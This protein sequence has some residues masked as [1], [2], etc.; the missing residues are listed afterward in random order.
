ML[1]GLAAA[2]TTTAAFGGSCS[3]GTGGGAPDKNRA[4]RRTGIEG[5]YVMTATRS[6]IDATPEHPEGANDNWGSFRL[7]LGK[8][9]FRM[10]DQRPAGAALVQQSSS[11]FSA[12]TYAVHGD[13]ITFSTRRASGDTPLGAAGDAPIVCRWSIYRSVLT[14]RELPANAK[15]SA[16]A[17][18]FG[19]PGPPLLY[20]KPWRRAK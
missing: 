11:G 17:R 7:V 19:A 16:L 9:R 14:F 2:L 10:A 8:T 13:R 18:G 6:E 15:A 5:T 3:G 4:A 1:I 12:G 20:V